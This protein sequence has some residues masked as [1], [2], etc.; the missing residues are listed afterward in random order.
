VEVGNEVDVRA[1]TGADSINI[2]AVANEGRSEG[3][4]RHL[5]LGSLT[6]VLS[7]L[8]AYTRAVGRAPV[9]EVEG[10]EDLHAIVGSRLVS[11]AELCISVRVKTNVQG[12]GVNA[13]GLSTLEI[14]IIVAG[15]GTLSNNANL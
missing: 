5:K 14:S 3:S 9:A 10:K 12:K 15:A 4:A 6:S 7:N 2:D 1:G 8:L 13:I 11:K